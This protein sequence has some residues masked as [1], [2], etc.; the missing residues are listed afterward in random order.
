MRV[1]SSRF[2]LILCAVLAIHA[3]AQES[4]T[5]SNVDKRRLNSF[6]IISSSAYAITL[7]GLNELWYKE[8]ERQSFTF[9]NDNHEW[10]Q[11]DKL[12]HFYSA[13][14][15]S[16]GTSKSLQWCG[17]KKNKSDLWGSVVGF[18][19]M[20]PIEIFDGFSA[21]YGASLGDLGA[22]AVGAGFYLGQ[23]LLWDEIR[24]HPKFSFHRTPYPAL[25]P[26][27]ILGDGM[28]SELIKD[29]NGQTYWLSVDMDKFIKFP[30]WLNIAV[31]YGADGMV[32]ATD[33]ENE[34]A[35]YRAVREYYLGIDFDLSHIK[36][37]SKALNT[38]LFFVNM[39]K[40]PAPAIRFSD[41][42]VTFNAFEF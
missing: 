23:S 32:Y 31:G 20:V 5:V 8:S 24:L 28:P 2:I 12:G 16:S 39:I 7:V 27:G 9:F 37:R 36:T 18:M 25:R 11:I 14:H 33:A 26:D 13:F 1:M 3:N 29:Y 38:F 15:L 34:A 42:K 30:K 4:D 10:K 6:I 21:N 22:N 17:V 35:G 41:N 19:L 40:L